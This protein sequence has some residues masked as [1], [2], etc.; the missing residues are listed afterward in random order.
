MK[1]RIATYNLE[2]LFTRP[3]AMLDDSK[4]G[5]QAIEDHALLNSIVQKDSYTADDKAELLRLDKRYRFSALILRRTHWCSCNRSEALSSAARAAA[6][7]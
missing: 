4:A 6:C 5:Q 2:N 3:S 1:V 7:T